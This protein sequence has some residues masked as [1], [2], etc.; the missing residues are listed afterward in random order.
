MSWLSSVSR[1]IPI[2]CPALAFPGVP[3]GPS[4]ARLRPVKKRAGRS[5][6]REQRRAILGDPGP[7]PPFGAGGFLA[8][9]F[10]RLCYGVAV[11]LT[12][13]YDA[14]SVW[15]IHSQ[16]GAFGGPYIPGRSF[17]S[18]HPPRLVRPLIDLRLGRVRATQTGSHSQEA[19]QRTDKPGTKSNPAGIIL[20]VITDRT[21]SMGWL[22]S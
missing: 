14:G 15:P 17:R 5:P 13:H 7:A 19:W 1:L 4:I 20:A 2:P 21:V 6:L 8:C 10:W 22:Y 3:L 12:V 11:P 16:L 18:L 9:P